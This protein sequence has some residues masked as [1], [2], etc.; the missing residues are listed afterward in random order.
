M[1][2]RLL[3]LAGLLLVPGIACEEAPPDGQPGAQEFKDDYKSQLSKEDQAKVLARIGDRA[4]TLVDFERHLSTQPPY[5]RARYASS[6]ER[7]KEFLDNLVRFEVLAAEAQ[8]RGYDRHPEVIQ[9]TKQTMVR[10][11]MAGDVD[12]TVKLAS[13]TDEEAKA[14]YDEHKSEYHKPEEA[15]VSHI[16][17]ETRADADKL[18]AR[19]HEEIAKDKR[20]YRKI[21]ADLAKEVSLDETT[22]DQGGDLRFF[23]RA[24]EGGEQPKALA[25]AAFAI[26]Q[27]GN[28][29]EP[30][31][32]EKGWHV[33]ML[34]G[35][36][37][38]YDR[39]F[40]QVKR[41]IQNRLFREKKRKTTEDFVEKLKQAAR[42][43]RHDD[44]LAKI[45]L[46]AVEPPPMQMA[47]PL[48][49]QGQPLPPGEAAP[50][51]PGALPAPGHKAPLSLTP[52][53]GLGQP[54]RALPPAA[55]GP[56]PTAAG[57]EG[58]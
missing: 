24:E 56:A 2:R 40:E 11:M 33:I 16:L 7:Q 1:R 21:F 37:N 23:A 26:D 18:L 39:D 30:V 29:G 22:K 27:V 17:V 45:K 5:A 3:L 49:P 50:A 54:P 12:D 6:P 25:D 20:N 48:D 42:I 15:R 28:L 41:Q 4:I 34:T 46:E 35:R 53:G 32:T 8:R 19:L 55:A 13:I 38:R 51:A 58:K 43:E 31:Q 44:L 14:Y 52:P 57:S 10:K 9:A 47:N 36:K